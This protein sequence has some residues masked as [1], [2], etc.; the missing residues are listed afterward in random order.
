[1]LSQLLAYSA[2]DICFV[3]G[4]ECLALHSVSFKLANYCKFVIY[5]IK[6]DLKYKKIYTCSF[7]FVVPNSQY[8]AF[9]YV[10]P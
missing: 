4:I 3:A 8:M 2:V 10:S 7:N 5:C 1:M 9:L 6:S